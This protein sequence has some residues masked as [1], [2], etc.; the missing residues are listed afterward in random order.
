MDCHMPGMDGFEAASKI[1]RL[2]R[3]QDRNRASF[4]KRV[5]G[6]RIDDPMLY[7]AIFNTE[8]V[9]IDAIVQTVI[10]HVERVDVR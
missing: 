9:P 2:E 10:H 5:Y 4:V 1:R 3:E 7:D 6:Q 8:R